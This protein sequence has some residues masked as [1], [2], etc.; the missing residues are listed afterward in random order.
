MIRVGILGTG[1]G[2]KVHLPAFQMDARCKVV[3][4]YGRNPS[5]L[6]EAFQD[7]SIRLHSSWEEILASPEVD[8]VA[9]ALP[10]FLQAEVLAQLPKYKKHVLAE[11]PIGLG[12]D[13]T[14][15]LAEALDKLKIVHSVDFEFPLLPAWQ[16]LY[17]KLAEISP[18]QH[19]KLNWH[20]RTTSNAVPNSWKP[21]AKQ[22][23]GTLAN[24]ACHSLHSV[25]WI[26]GKAQQLTASLGENEMQV[27]VIMEFEGHR[28]AVVSVSM[29]TMFGNGH[30]VEVFGDKGALT[31]ENTGAD[32]MNGFVLKIKNQTGE[33]IETFPASS[34]FADGRVVA[35]NRIV[36]RF[37]DAIEGM[38]SD[39]RPDLFEG[40]RNERLLEAC[41]ESHRS[42]ERVK[43]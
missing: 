25:E 43:I 29:N 20:V 18:V 39:Y 31:L 9:I 28:K 16:G 10:P 26:M 38:N 19:L 13:K 17:G 40:A 30:R 14:K 23:G 37:L 8:A 34:T 27:D 32:Y 6:R 15:K 21:D 1:F 22:G 7:P 11:K 24:L 35:V 12:S 33:K 42:G 41:R 3:A 2:A 36:K 5:K 4:A